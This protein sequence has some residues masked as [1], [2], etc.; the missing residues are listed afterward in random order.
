M[1][2]FLC[3]FCRKKPC[4]GQLRCPDTALPALLKAYCLISSLTLPGTCSLMISLWFSSFR[5]RA[6][7]TKITALSVIRSATAVQAHTVTSNFAQR[8]A[9]SYTLPCVL[10]RHAPWATAATVVTRC[11]AQFLPYQG[12]MT[13]LLYTEDLERAFCLWL[14]HMSLSNYVMWPVATVMTRATT[15]Q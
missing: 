15:S 8:P 2:K 14:F 11:F 10:Q 1:P 13:L 6:N 4:S 7:C 9:S 12:W 5:T 3:L